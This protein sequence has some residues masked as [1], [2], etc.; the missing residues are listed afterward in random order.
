MGEIGIKV[1]AHNEGETCRLSHIKGTSK[2]KKR[3]KLWQNWF[4]LDGWGTRVVLE[5]SEEKTSSLNSRV[6]TEP[7][8]QCR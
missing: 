2:R 4:S 3:R 7:A 1:E 8:R 5:S 6:E